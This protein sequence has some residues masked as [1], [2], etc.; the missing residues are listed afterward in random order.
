[1]AKAKRS[2]NN[3]S[4]IVVLV[5]T[6]EKNPFDLIDGNKVIGSE[7]IKLD[8]GDY[9][10][11]GI[12]DKWLC[13]ERK[14]G[15]SELYASLT[16]QRERFYKEI[17]RMKSFHHKFIVIEA[18]SEDVINPEEYF[19]IKNKNKQQQWAIRNSATKV[20]RNSLLSLMLIHGIHVLFIGRDRSRSRQWIIS[21]LD[22]AYIDWQKNNG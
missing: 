11:K 12:D 3:G 4:G 10:I 14:S 18:E 5:D 7:S 17:D 15:I 2:A 21:I 20:V 1:M 19:W 9:T 6:R 16:S 13:I 8:T 22:R